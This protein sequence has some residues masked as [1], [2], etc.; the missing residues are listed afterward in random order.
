MK[1]FVLTQ[2]PDIHWKN[3]YSKWAWAV[4]WC[5]H[6]PCSAILSWYWVPY[7][8]G[9]FLQQSQTVHGPGRD[10]VWSMRHLQGEPKGMPKREGKCSH[11]EMWMRIC[12]MDQRGPTCFC[13]VDGHTS[14]VCVLHHLSYVFRWRHR[15][16]HW[17]VRDIPCPTP[18]IAYNKNMG[19]V[20]LLDQLFQYYSTCRKTVCLHK[21]V[22]LHFLDICQEEQS[23]ISKMQSPSSVESNLRA[24]AYM[25]SSSSSVSALLQWWGLQ[26]LAH[27]VLVLTPCVVLTP[28]C[29]PQGPHE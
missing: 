19:G 28:C 13:E 9:Q 24:P 12:E 6:E 1:L 20:D 10:E 17:V 21:T 3:K 26:L 22:M 5:G 15:A 18:I 2:I 7:L 23:S 8:H 27:A 25:C 14:G 29:S 4:L 16:G 11:Q